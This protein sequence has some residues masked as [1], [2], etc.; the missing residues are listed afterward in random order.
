[1]NRTIQNVLKDAYEKWQ[2]RDYIWTRIEDKFTAKSFGET[3]ND[4]LALSESL[5][6][7]NL[8][9][10][11]IMIYSENSY[12]WMVSDLSIM[13]F[14]GTTIAVNKEW[15]V[16]DL[17]NILNTC[18]A[19]AIIY[20]NSKKDTI[21]QIRETHKDLLYISIQDEF[22]AL[23]DKG[24]KIIQHKENKFDFEERD[25]RKESKI[26]FSSGTTSTPK[27]VMLSQ[28]NMFA[29]WNSLY[30]RAPLNERD[31]C[32]LFLPLNH[33]YAGIYNLLYS[34]IGG[35][36]IYLCSDTS[37]MAEE[38]KIVKPTVL[39]VVPAV[40]EIFYKA[41]DEAVLVN[42]NKVIK[43]SNALRKRKIDIRKRLFKK[44]HE[45]FGGDLKYMFCGGASFNN[46]I[47][48]FYKEVGF[49]IM[50]AYALT[51]T[52]SSFSI[53][54]SDSES[55]TSS[56]R[57]FEDIEVKFVDKDEN[58]N[59]E[60]LVKGDCV[61]LGYYGNEKA[62]QEAF[63]DEGFFRT[64]DIGYKDEHNNLYIVGRK[65]RVLIGSNGENIYPDE[66]EEMIM[67]KGHAGI[68]KVKVYERN[69]AIV[70][71]IYV[72]DEEI[73]LIDVIKKTNSLLPKYKQIREFEKI[74]DTINTRLK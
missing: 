21:D 24:H 35:W 59:G 43:V 33:T 66:I 68:A 60:I 3:I 42:L 31:I 74:I 8:Q 41:I 34:L 46:T 53:E 49:N 4:V 6:S 63:D 23:L 26:V 65:K 73:D 16:Y 55:M 19:T 7:M 5:L 45:I 20:S 14:V 47:R 25:I 50:E 52:A 57:I 69:G 28:I 58:G 12:E 70:A 62:T 36:Q 18:D 56:G 44:I 32:Y 27:A 48:R 72:T 29:G 10:K 13:G 67:G 40:L 38:L 54:Y 11:K 15:G 64:G 61:C 39:C 22:P 9:D 17:T 51:E 1:M 30:K 71:S 37:K 2:N